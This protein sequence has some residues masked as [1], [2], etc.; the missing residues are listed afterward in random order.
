MIRYIL[1]AQL[2]K[3]YARHKVMCVC[4][5]CVSVMG[6]NSPLLKWRYS[7]T[8]NLRRQS[9]WSKNKVWWKRRSHIPII[10]IQ[11]CQLDVIFMP[12]H[13]IQKKLQCVNILSLIIHCHTG[14]MYYYAVL[15]AHVSIFL[16]NKQIISIQKQ[17]PQYSFTFIASLD[18]VLLMVELHWKTKIYVTCVNKN[19]HQINLQKYTPEKS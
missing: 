16:T 19:L 4:E 5:C 10:K 18:V 12:K 17:H 9:K 13:L 14:N 1:P 11:L 8:K 2:K 6:I 7:Y 3:M 15:N